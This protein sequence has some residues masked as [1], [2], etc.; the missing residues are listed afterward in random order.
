M[1]KRIDSSY[2][3]ASTR[4]QFLSRAGSGL[5]ALAFGS[6][7]A[8]QGFGAAVE[9]PL[10]AKEPHHPPKAKSVIWLF[11]EGGASHIDTFDPKPLLKKLAGQPTPDSFDPPKV[12]A[13]GT[14][15]NTLMPD[16]RQW[17]Q[18]GKSGLWVSDWY[19]HVAEH[20]DDLCVIR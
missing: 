1:R 17:A 3:H 13:M 7:L 16:Q 10:E 9:N 15:G 4:R 6:L 12:T 2:L 5:G 20:V 14:F 18:H 19:S 8:E 11:M